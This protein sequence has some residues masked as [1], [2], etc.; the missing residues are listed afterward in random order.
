MT[1]ELALN[2]RW[3]LAIEYYLVK[4]NVICVKID[5]NIE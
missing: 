4:E 5:K 1:K 3:K 2:A